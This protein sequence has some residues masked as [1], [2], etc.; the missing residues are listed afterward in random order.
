MNSVRR[1][2]CKGSLTKDWVDQRARF[3]Y[4]NDAGGKARWNGT[5]WM[6]PT[7]TLLDCSCWPVQRAEGRCIQV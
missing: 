1:L 3:P 7:C 5:A 2:T 6:L 4:F